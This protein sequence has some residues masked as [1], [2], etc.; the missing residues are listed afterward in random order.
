MDIC[1]K[2]YATGYEFDAC[3]AVVYAARPQTATSTFVKQ[4]RTSVKEQFFEHA[5][6]ATPAKS[7][8]C[9]CRVFH[10]CRGFEPREAQRVINR[11]DQCTSTELATNTGHFNIKQCPIT[12]F[13]ECR[14]KPFRACAE[15]RELARHCV[16]KRLQR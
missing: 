13:A 10:A 6:D 16:T 11:R 12:I 5:F 2:S 15:S 3:I 1:T 4:K 14:D 8:K 9:A 7:K